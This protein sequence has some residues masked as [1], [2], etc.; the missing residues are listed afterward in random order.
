MSSWKVLKYVSSKS[1][2]LSV[3]Q[4]S[5]IRPHRIFDRISVIRLLYPAVSIASL[6]NINIHETYAPYLYKKHIFYL[7]KYSKILWDYPLKTTTFFT[8]HWS[9]DYCLSKK[10]LTNKGVETRMVGSELNIFSNNLWRIYTQAY[11]DLLESPHYP[12]QVAAL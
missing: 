8:F 5:G 7:L 1:N 4:I 10:V 9:K 12:P 6:E 3:I 2:L 11:G